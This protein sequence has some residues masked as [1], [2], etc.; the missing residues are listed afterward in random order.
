MTVL[1]EERFGSKYTELLK[2]NRRLYADKHG[3]YAGGGQG[4]N[5]GKESRK[6]EKG[7]KGNNVMG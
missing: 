2:E 7:K 3:T 4:I 5:K 6:R 1:D